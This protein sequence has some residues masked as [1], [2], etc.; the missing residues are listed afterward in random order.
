MQDQLSSIEMKIIQVHD[1]EK[2]LMCEFTNVNDARQWY[3]KWKFSGRYCDGKVWFTCVERPEG[4]VCKKY[5]PTY[6]N[7]RAFECH[8]STNLTLYDVNACTRSNHS[9]QFH[10]IVLD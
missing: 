9:N 7:G 10:A 1:F 3:N 4:T 2:N 8:S 6:L 5:V